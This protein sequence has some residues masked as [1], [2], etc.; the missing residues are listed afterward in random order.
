MTMRNTWI[1][2]GIM[3]ALFW[4]FLLS[5]T[6]FISVSVLCLT[7]VLQPPTTNTVEEPLDLIRLSLDERIYVKMRNDRE[8]RGRL[9][10]SCMLQ[11]LR[12][13]SDLWPVCFVPIQGLNRYSCF[14][15]H[16]GRLCSQ[17][18]RL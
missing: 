18:N 10:V 17:G 8:L 15:F 16:L 2:Y 13:L 6:L 4:H 9:H 7:A 3:E 14:I 1:L 12:V 5:L 11:S